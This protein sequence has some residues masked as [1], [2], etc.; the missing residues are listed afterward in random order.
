MPWFMEEI[1]TEDS[2]GLD[3]ATTAAS[4]SKLP[5]ITSSPSGLP[6]FL[7]DQVFPTL[8]NKNAN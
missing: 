2:P 7:H 4:P 5:E 8:L 3:S 6:G 1:W